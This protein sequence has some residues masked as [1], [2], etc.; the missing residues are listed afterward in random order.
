ML[1]AG[2]NTRPRGK[3]CATPCE[4]QFPEDMG[5][6]REAAGLDDI[7]DEPFASDEDLG[8]EG[9]H[10]PRGGGPPMALGDPPRD[11]PFH[12][13]EGDRVT[14]LRAMKNV[15]KLAQK[16]VGGTAGVIDVK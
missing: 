15:L 1:G 12:P 2:L 11:E 3:P 14:V 16:L 7:P 6:D 9:M 5:G 13:K 8:S 4:V 10:N